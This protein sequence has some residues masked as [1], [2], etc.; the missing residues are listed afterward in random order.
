MTRDL[1]FQL[2]LA[3]VPNIGHR[4]ARALTEHFGTAEEVFKAGRHDLENIEGIGEVT[5]RSIKSFRDFSRAEKEIQ[6]ITQYGIEALYIKSKAYPQRLLNCQDPPPLLFYKGN[7]DLNASRV[8]AIVG[9]RNNTEYGKSFTEKLVKTLSHYNCLIIS[10]LAFGIDSIA[11]KCSLKHGVP[12]VGVVGHGLDTIYPRQHSGLAKQ[13]VGHGGLRTEFRS[14]TI[15]DKH[16]FPARN[17]VVAGIADAT[18]IVE[19]GV[20]GGSIITADLAFGYHRDVF[21]VPG[22]TI[23]TK[24]GGCNRL[25]YENRAAL[26]LDPEHFV[27]AM[28]WTQAEKKDE[29]HQKEM[30]IQ[31]SEQERTV[32]ELLR[33]NKSLSGDELNFRTDISAGT[34]ATVLLN[35]E[36]QGVLKLM[37]G[38][39]YVLTDD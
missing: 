34:L 20:K 28:G 15:P 18:I 11:H 24:S 35:L 21:A 38:S 9:T 13:L 4:N 17:R 10:G 6:F 2:A 36:M 8:V 26:L 37:P 27:E 22:R 16:N 29:S 14:P 5:A 12:T 19:S 31:L 23:D 25:I 3:D 39:R 32:V 30:F 1:I 33:I 7:A